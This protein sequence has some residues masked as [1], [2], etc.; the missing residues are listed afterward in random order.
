MMMCNCFYQLNT[1]KKTHCLKKE[2]VTYTCIVLHTICTG[3][4]V[5]RLRVHGTTYSHTSN[6]NITHTRSYI[7]RGAHI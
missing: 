7:Y 1:I 6:L 4:V 3:G 2:Q 5:R